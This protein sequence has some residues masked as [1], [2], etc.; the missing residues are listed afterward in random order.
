MSPGRKSVEEVVAGSRAVLIGGSLR[1]ANVLKGKEFVVVQEMFET[2][3]TAYAD[4]VLPASSFAEVDGTY[5]NNTGFVQ[6]VRMAINPL[7]LSKPDWHITTMLAREM[8]S[9]FGYHFSASMVFKQIA[10]TIPA[11]A[12]LRY[13]ALKDESKPVQVKHALAGPRDLTAYLNVMSERVANFPVGRL[14]VETP[15]VG[16]KLHQ[17]TV[18]TGKTPQFHLLAHGN[19]KPQNLLVSPLLQFELDGTPREEEIAIAVGLEDRANLGV[20]R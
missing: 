17:V 5:T 16:H 9:D 4:V 6:R 13:P 20:N 11:Y 7:H 10:D 3:T 18:M 2:E 8:G 12:G 1:A 19:P 15:R 14:N